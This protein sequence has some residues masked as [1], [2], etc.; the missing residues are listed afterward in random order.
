MAHPNAAPIDKAMPVPAH[1]LPLR[2]LI[3]DD[4]EFDARRIKRTLTAV[5]PNIQVS[6]VST[7]TDY[8]RRI[9]SD[10][11]DVL[12]IDYFLPDGDGLT[13]L[14]MASDHANGDSLASIM[15]AGENDPVVAEAAK[16]F[17]CAS[18][19]PKSE[20]TTEVLRKALNLTLSKTV[21]GDLLAF[22]RLFAPSSEAALD[23]VAETVVG[24]MRPYLMR[25]LRASRKLRELSQYRDDDVLTETSIEIE[26]SC[27]ATL[28][29]LAKFEKLRDPR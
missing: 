21:E 5:D 9:L 17:G 15:V 4:S 20:I 11:F 18:Y 16:G 2:V 26:H 27:D 22:Q 7:L 23:E 19:L 3:L 10:R 8:Y 25:L 29:L 6:A 24:P 28:S 14:R 1:A 13:A 12:I